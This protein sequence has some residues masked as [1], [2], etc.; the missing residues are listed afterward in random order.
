MTT[1]WDR[2][3]VGTGL[4]VGAGTEVWVYAPPHLLPDIRKPPERV[5]PERPRLGPPPPPEQTPAAR[6]T[7]LAEL[8][9]LDARVARRWPPAGSTRSSAS[10]RRAPRRS[11]G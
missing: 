4:N 11:P 2:L 9:G 10:P 8:R 5:I 7:P 1:A 6:L 3:Y